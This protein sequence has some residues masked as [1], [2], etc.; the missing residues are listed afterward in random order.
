MKNNDNDKHDRKSG[1]KFQTLVY[2]LGVVLVVLSLY[3]FWYASELQTTITSYE[4]Q[5]NSARLMRDDLVNILDSYIDSTGEFWRIEAMVGYQ[6]DHGEITEEEANYTINVNKYQ[7][8]DP[9]GLV[10]SKLLVWDP[11]VITPDGMGGFITNPEFEWVFTEEVIWVFWLPKYYDTIAIVDDRYS[12]WHNIRL[13][14]YFKYNHTEAL[15]TKVR[16]GMTMQDKVDLSL[17]WYFMDVY[18]FKFDDYVEKNI[19]EPK[20]NLENEIERI[21][22][23]I[24]A[25]TIGVLLLG[26]IIDFGRIGR[27]WKSFYIFLVLSTI[28]SSLLIS[29]LIFI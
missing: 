2:G 7:L 12:S 14:P 19:L 5:L 16:H 26:F 18:M 1:K 3:Q 28:F 21:G 9:L 10:I 8:L 6:Y 11:N 13:S 24:T 15:I 25:N 4:E 23:A 29:V 27:V 22:I 17:N 20:L